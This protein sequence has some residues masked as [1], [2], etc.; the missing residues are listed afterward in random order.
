MNVY[1]V[2][3]MI[4]NHDN[5]EEDKIASVLE[6]ARYPNMC[7]SPDVV[8]IESKDIGEWDDDSPFNGPDRD[9]YFKVLFDLPRT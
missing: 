9:K 3:L 4:V 1:K 2:T 7:I 6:N 5:L 8:E